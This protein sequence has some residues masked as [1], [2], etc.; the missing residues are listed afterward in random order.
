MHRDL[1]TS[2]ARLEPTDHED[3][4]AIVRDAELV[5]P[6]VVGNPRDPAT[7]KYLQIQHGELNVILAFTSRKKVGGFVT[8]TKRFVKAIGSDLAANIPAGAAIGLNL[9]QPDARLFLPEVIAGAPVSD[10]Q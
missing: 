9:G 5:V 6:A 7:G 4:W 8:Q 2:L 1:E 10:A 3:A